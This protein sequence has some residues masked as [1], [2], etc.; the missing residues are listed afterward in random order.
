MTRQRASPQNIALV[1]ADAAL[2]DALTGPMR[3][4]GV[5]C[6]PVTA[7][8]HDE[9][10]ALEQLRQEVTALH[11]AVV[12]GLLDDSRP[13][14]DVPPREWTQMVEACLWSAIR[15]I[16]ACCEAIEPPGSVVALTALPG[17]TGVSGRVAVGAVEEGVRAF[18]RS[19]AR[20]WGTDGI[21]VN[22]VVMPSVLALEEPPVIW[23]EPVE[24][25][26]TWNDVAASLAVLL[27][28]N[29]QGWTG[30]TMPIGG[31]WL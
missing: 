2:R 22:S 18:V 27:G 24:A 25:P 7:D 19:A 5:V 30:L 4:H 23:P 10:A 12:T 6:L 20:R 3:E 15:W 13:I 28:P 21:R 14:L 16:T 1:T 17:L 26:R 11:G 29:T 31:E 8:S 9:R